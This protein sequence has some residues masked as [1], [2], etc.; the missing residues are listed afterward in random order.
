MSRTQRARHTSRPTRS[1]EAEGSEEPRCRARSG[2]S[3]TRSQRAPVTPK[4]AKSREGEYGPGTPRGRHSR[5]AVGGEDPRCRARSGPGTP[6][7]RRAPVT[8]REA[9]SRD[10]AHAAGQAQLAANAFPRRRGLRRAE[11]SRTQRAR[12]TSQPTRSSDAEGGEE[13]R[14][15]AR[16]GPATRLEKLPVRPCAPAQLAVEQAVH[17]GDLSLEEAALPTAPKSPPG[18]K[19]TTEGRW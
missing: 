6:R 2:P 8:P 3:T 7:G 1:R 12:H 11:M 18:A 4:E 15:R 5:D 16:S 10:V 17:H 19:A 9:K 13:P 14:C